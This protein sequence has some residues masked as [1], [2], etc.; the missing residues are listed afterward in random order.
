MTPSGHGKLPTGTR[1]RQAA[2]RVIGLTGGIAAGKS[3]VARFFEKAGVPVIDADQVARELSAPGGAAHEAILKR[4]GTADRTELR[5]IVFG[6]P[7]ARQ[8]LESILHPLIRAESAS[9]IARLAAPVVLYE[10]A[11][12]VETGRAREL[13]GLVVVEAPREQRL[14]RLRARDGI[15]EELAARMLDAQTSDEERRNA[16]TEVIVNA[17]G[18]AELEQ[19]VAAL[20]AR[21]RG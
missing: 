3:T 9:R 6:D 13:D 5:K 2:C 16:A 15:Q 1:D 18:L 8:D 20:A 14:R 4:F 17:G 10:A 21:W 7:A 12:L 19:K 11:L